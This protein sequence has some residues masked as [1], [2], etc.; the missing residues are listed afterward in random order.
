MGARDR[1]QER[2]LAHAIGAHD[3]GHLA[4]LRH[5]VDAVKDLRP[6]VVKRKPLGFQHVQRPR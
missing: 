4:R 5:H 1:L 3:A 6:A 2:G